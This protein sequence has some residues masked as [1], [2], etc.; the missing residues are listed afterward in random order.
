MTA[1]EKVREGPGHKE[2]SQTERDEQGGLY[3][4]Q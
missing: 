2:E 3:S 4:E 1:G